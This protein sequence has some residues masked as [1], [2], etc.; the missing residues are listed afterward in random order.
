MKDFLRARILY[1]PKWKVFAAS[2]AR[3]SFCRQSIDKVVQTTFLPPLCYFF[4]YC[5]PIAF[6]IEVNAAAGLSNALHWDQKVHQLHDF[7]ILQLNGGPFSLHLVSAK[8]KTAAPCQE[9]IL[10]ITGLLKMQLKASPA[11]NKHTV[12]VNSP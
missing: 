4:S 9:R 12:T 2:D 1:R 3:S 7:M 10:R 5:R 8:G 6:R 11:C